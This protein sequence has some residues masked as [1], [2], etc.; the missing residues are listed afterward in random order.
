MTAKQENA[1]HQLPGIG[2]IQIRERAHQFQ[3]DRGDEHRGDALV[4]GQHRH[5]NEFARGGPVGELRIDVALRHQ[6]QRAAGAGENRRDDEID[7]DDA[8]GGKAEIFHPQIVFTH[9]EAGKAKLGAEQDGRGDAGKAGGDHR[10]R[11]QHEIRLAGVAEDHAEQAGAADIESVGAAERGRLEQRA[12]QHHRQRQRQ[13]AEE[14]AAVARNQ[15][16]DHKAKQAA[17]HRADDDLQHGIGDPRSVGDQRHAVAAGGEEQPWPER[18]IAGARQHHDA[19][20]DQRIGGG[21]R[22][23]RQRPGRQHAAEQR[24]CTHQRDHDHGV[25]AAS[26]HIR[27]AVSRW[28]RPSGRNISTAAMIR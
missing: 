17:A 8:V 15:R 2:Q 10:D 14:D 24:G 7:G 4:S 25:Q 16:P 20:R 23:Q 28:N 22:R 19:E 13:H 18:H 26:H 3:R 6:G 21:H 1:E 9:R 11:I 27:L 12:I 5:E